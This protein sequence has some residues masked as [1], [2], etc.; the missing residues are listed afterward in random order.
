V[1]LAPVTHNASITPGL[2]ADIVSPSR[3]FEYAGARFQD[4]IGAIE[5]PGEGRAANGSAV[6][7]AIAQASSGVR[8][9]ESV[10]V[11]SSPSSQRSTASQAMI[12]ARGGI[13]A[14]TR[15]EAAVAPYGA[16]TIERDSLGDD[17]LADLSSGYMHL[18]AA[19]ERIAPR[20]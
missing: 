15:Y 13:A 20:G 9:L 3:L 16:G 19:L 2:P 14:L 1:L 6:R 18:V 5:S 8:A 11:P 17:V 7:T 4:A 12:L 10:M